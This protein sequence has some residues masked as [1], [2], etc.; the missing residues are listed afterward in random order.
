MRAFGM[1]VER[2]LFGNQMICNSGYF[3]ISAFSNHLLLLRENVLGFCS[4]S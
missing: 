3:D 2:K 1:A 4:P